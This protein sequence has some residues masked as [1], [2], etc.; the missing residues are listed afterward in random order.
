MDAKDKK[1]LYLLD[2]NSRMK[3]PDLA[4]QLGTSKQVVNYRIKRLESEGVIK[5]FQSVLNLESQGISIYANIYFKIVG[6]NKKREAEII[7]FLIKDN[8]VG[9][10]ALLGGRF[11]LS[12]VLVAK[13]IQELEEHL[14][15]I[16]KEFPDELREYIISLRT[17]GLKFYKKYLF[18]ER[19]EENKKILT[20]EKHLVKIDELDVKILKEL[21][22]NSRESIV[23]ISEKLKEPF[24]TIRARIKSLEQNKVIVGYSLLFDLNKI[25][26]L[27]YKV[28]IKTKDKSEES[29]KKLI[30]FSKFHKNITWFFKTLGEHDFELRIEVDTQ[31][32]Y[33]EIIKEI[34]SEFS[35]IINELETIIIFNELKED[36]SVV[37]SNK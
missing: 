2:L 3:E 18:Q 7:D 34:R 14:N 24:S 9:Y 31:E 19:R 32:K 20:K 17:E 16:V 4:K 8:N 6:A 33:Q 5:K 36:Y 21:S 26:M 11:D 37:L 10:V 30:S 22:Q 29:Y 13:N 1:L 27:N 35:S 15:E 28:F 12:I 25:G 23:N